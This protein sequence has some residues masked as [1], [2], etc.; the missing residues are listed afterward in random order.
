MVHLTHAGDGTNRLF[1]VLQPGR[2]VVFE[3]DPGVESAQTFLDIRERVSAP[4]SYGSEEG[5]L[6]LAFDPGYS[7]NGYFYVYYSASG[8]R[9]SVISRFSVSPGDANRGDPASELVLL[10]VGQPFSNH[11]GGHLVFGPDGM[12]YAGLGDGGAAGDPH[13]NG[14]DISTLLGSVLR[15]DVS[16]VDAQGSYAV[17]EDNPFAGSGGDARGEIWAYGLRNPWR[18]SFDRETGILWAADVGQNLYEEV[19]VIRPGLN[20]GWNVME[21]SHCFGQARCDADGLEMPVAEYGRGGG[22]SVIGGHVYRGRSMASLHGAYLYGDFCSGKIWALR[23]DGASVTEHVEIADTGLSI[24]SFG[25]D[26]SGEVYVLTFEG[27]IYRF[28]A[29]QPK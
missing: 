14:Q 1:L 13:D 19:N 16:S 9:R 12:L 23:Y 18:F 11:N 15:V 29:Q 17:P 25:E 28:T 22:C 21:G 2:V 4:E 8:P 26:A 20:Y 3:N 27:V 24:S 5:L 6:G 7:E 10:E